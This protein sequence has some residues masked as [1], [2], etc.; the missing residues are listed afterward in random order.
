[1]KSDYD[2]WVER[3]WKT[4][5]RQFVMENPE[6]FNELCRQEWAKCSYKTGSEV[7]HGK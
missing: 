1:M 3:N 5:V 4:L 2:G 7:K 6:S